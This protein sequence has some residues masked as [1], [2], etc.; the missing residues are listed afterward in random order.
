MA[1]E[2]SYYDESEALRMARY[3]ASIGEDA[4]KSL[5][6]GLDTYTPNGVSNEIKVRPDPF[7]NFS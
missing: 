4:S 6:S 3:N 1:I 5:G 2:K 7:S